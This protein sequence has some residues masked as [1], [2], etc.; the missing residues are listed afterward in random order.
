MLL[1]G[2]EKYLYKGQKKGGLG[3]REGNE[4]KRKEMREGRGKVGVKP[5]ATELVSLSI[6]RPPC[7][8]QAF[9]I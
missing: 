6:L 1:F 5:A 7:S 9:N 8:L 2:V 4:M 3:L